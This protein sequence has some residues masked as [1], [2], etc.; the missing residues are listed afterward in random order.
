MPLSRLLSH[1]DGTSTALLAPAVG[2]LL[3]SK[4]SFFLLGAIALDATALFSPV[5]LAGGTKLSLA[6]IAENCPLGT[7]LIMT[8]CW[9]LIYFL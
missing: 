7:T 5:L 3:R 1:I 9:S 8:A 6:A 4:V 2:I